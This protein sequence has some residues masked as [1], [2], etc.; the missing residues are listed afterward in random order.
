[1]ASS[2]ARPV[3]RRRLVA[4]YRVACPPDP[5]PATGMHDTR[6]PSRSVTPW[7]WA[8]LVAV[9]ALW[10]W[11]Y[12]APG[13]GITAAGAIVGIV[14]AVL[15]VLTR[16]PDLLDGCSFGRKAWWAFPVLAAHLVVS[17]VAIPVV[18]A[19]LPIV[20]DQATVLVA[21]ATSTL[22]TSV[23]ALIAAVV[24]APLEEVWWRGI[25]QPRLRGAPT[26]TSVVGGISV[27]G[28]WAVARTTVVFCLFHLV[29]GNI[30][31]IGAAL[32]GGVAWG[33]LRER[34]GGLA[35]PMLAHAGWTAAMALW[36]PV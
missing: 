28:W 21:G 18:T 10:A 19:V 30:A 23:V 16:G 15:A 17:Y 27:A 9:T 7:Q 12:R 1:M 26:T 36:P 25:L 29:T 2:Y 35:A 13:V 33:W 5:D 32:L 6:T 34:T 14:L 8:G 4:T 11:L 24:V 31:L 3:A 20:K 22:P